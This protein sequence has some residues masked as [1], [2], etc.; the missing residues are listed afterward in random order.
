MD[1][2]IQGAGSIGAA[3]VNPSD[4][5]ARARRTEGTPGVRATTPPAS[6]DAIPS[7]PPPEVLEQ[8]AQAQRVFDKLSQEGQSLHFDHDDAGRVTVELRGSDGQARRLSL[9]EALALVGEES[10]E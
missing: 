4:T 9:S 5:S 1:A 7:S 3:Q 10:S 6:L 8:M 2:A